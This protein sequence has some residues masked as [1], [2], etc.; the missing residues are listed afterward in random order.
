MKGRIL[1][2]CKIP[3]KTEIK[4]IGSRTFKKNGI[5]PLFAMPPNTN[6]TPWFAYESSF[7]KTLAIALIIIKPNFVFRGKAHN[8]TQLILVCMRRKEKLGRPYLLQLQ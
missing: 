8:R 4:T 3:I 2:C 7:P 6:S 5:D 1:K